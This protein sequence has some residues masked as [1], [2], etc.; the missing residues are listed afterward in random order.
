MTDLSNSWFLL[1]ACGGVIAFAAVLAF[2][3]IQEALQD[4]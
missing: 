4:R 1:L 2:V 3:S